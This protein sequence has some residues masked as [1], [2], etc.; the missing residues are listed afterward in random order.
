[1]FVIGGVVV[2]L[3]VLLVGGG[4]AAW[5][6]M[7]PSAS[8]GPGGESAVL[9]SDQP[10]VFAGDGRPN[11][12]AA[13]ALRYRWKDGPHIY[14]MRPEVDHSDHLEI[15]EGNVTLNV[16]PRANRPAVG[17][18]RQGTGTGFT[19]NS[20][21]YIVTCAHCVNGAKKIDATI[22]GKTY[23]AQ[24]IGISQTADVAVI[25]IAA[26][27]LP[28]LALANSDAAEVGQDVWALGF[29]LSD[30]LGNNL[31]AT[32]G[33]LSGLNNKGGRKLLQVDAAVN[34]GNSGGPLVTET[35]LVLGVTSSKLA[36]GDVSNVGFATPANEAKKL[37]TSKNV[38][39]STDGWNNKLDGPTLV[40]RVSAATVFLQVVLGPE[41]E[42]LG[43]V[44]SFQGF[45]PKFQQGKPGSNFMPGFPGLQSAFNG[46][47]EMDASGQVLHSSGG[48]QLP[49]LLGDVAQ[50]LIDP[51]PDDDR[52][53]WEVSATWTIEEVSGGGQDQPFGPFGMPGMP[54]MP[55]VPRMP[56]ARG[57]P[58]C[59]GCRVDRV[60]RSALG[61]AP[62]A[63]AAA[64]AKTANQRRAPVR[65]RPSIPGSAELATRCGFKS[66]MR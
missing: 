28:T 41:S 45:L 32:R 33:T 42:E 23:P 44:V 63:L 31:K 2:L 37:L 52:A 9:A 13:T 34:P 61:S 30:M 25:R 1:M 15:H 43:H 22:G 36:G 29:P 21:G 38:A 39:F 7:K 51:L 3:L 19:I 26:Q 58:A 35:G 46:K 12:P 5:L 14:H 59:P 18:D 16:T 55:G 27:G 60:G 47:L 48:H 40:K 50:F 49:C 10:G 53:S 57:C 56:G 8:S 54:R 62:V 17:A 24:V 6:V 66:A 11:S 4:V 65:T 20:N 64:A